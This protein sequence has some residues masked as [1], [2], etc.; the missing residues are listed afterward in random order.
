MDVGHVFTYGPHA[1]VF[2][3]VNRGETSLPQGRAASIARLAIVP[4]VLAVGALLAW[5]AGYFELDS[6]RE[7]LERVQR[8]RVMPGIES[9]FI[10]FYVL[11]V[12][13][14]LPAT[15][16]T[17]L[18]GA[19]FGPWFGAL[20]AW[21]GAMVGTVL[22]HVLARTIAR[23]PM[24]RLFGEHRILKMLREHDGVMALLRLRVLPVAPFGV[25]DY[26]AGVAGVSLRRL[27]VAT[28]AGVSLNVIAYAFVGHALL[29]GALSE[30]DG[31]RRAI[32]IAAGVTLVM[33][34]LSFVP[35]LFHRRS[36]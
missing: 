7:L 29:S 17:V 32:W 11:V 12:V 33:L 23:R 10:G 19:I 30:S 15:A 4:G 31:S 2:R 22:A 5:K 35:R 18:G 25:L 26:V 21:V 6:R 34:S 13:L 9:L 28:A 14:C 1:I 36:S 8:L 27:L 16:A 24:Q 20:L 3:V